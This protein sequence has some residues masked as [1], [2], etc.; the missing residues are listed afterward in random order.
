MLATARSSC[1]HSLQAETVTAL[2]ADVDRLRS[3]LKTSEQQRS[4]LTERVDQLNKQLSTL[5]QHTSPTPGPGLGKP[6]LTDSEV[7]V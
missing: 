3:E 6:S 1:V 4:S 5:R 7:E 2:R